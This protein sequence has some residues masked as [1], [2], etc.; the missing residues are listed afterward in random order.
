[1]QE[2]ERRIDLHLSLFRSE[3]VKRGREVATGV[4]LSLLEIAHALFLDAPR[5][6]T[7]H[8]EIIT[9]CCKYNFICMR[10]RERKGERERARERKRE[11]ERA[12]GEAKDDSRDRS[13]RVRARLI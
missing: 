11:K 7:S 1:M 10:E 2:G 13:G 3:K 12:R 6:N 8:E 4:T 5:A 9:L